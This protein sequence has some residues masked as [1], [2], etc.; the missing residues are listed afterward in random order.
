MV[1]RNI[2]MR[3]NY[4]RVD[5]GRKGWTLIAIKMSLKARAVV[6]REEES[7][8]CDPGSEFRLLMGGATEGRM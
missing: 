1:F 2:Y 4:T 3:R 5:E 8:L 7:L 6:G